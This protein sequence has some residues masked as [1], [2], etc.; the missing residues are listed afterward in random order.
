MITIP[1]GYNLNNNNNSIFVFPT[2][3]YSLAGNTIIHTPNQGTSREKNFNHIIYKRKMPTL[4]GNKHLSVH[5]FVHGPRRFHLSTGKV[6]VQSVR[7]GHQSGYCRANT[8]YNNINK[9]S[10]KFSLR[11]N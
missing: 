3:T 7:N 2:Y 9:R 10:K 8:I 4:A 1:E 6:R 5:C 11:K